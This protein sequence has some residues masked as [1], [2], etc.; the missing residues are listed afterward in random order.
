[1]T[2][3]LALLLVATLVAGG[4]SKP[5][6]SGQWVVNAA[7]S[8]FG[9]I[10]PPQCRGLKL[11]HREPELVSE[12]TRPGGEPC[13]LTLRYTTDGTP[14]TYT[15]NDARQRARMTWSGGTLVIERSSDD[16]VLMLIDATLSA[17]GRKL[18]VLSGRTAGC[19]ELDVRL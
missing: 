11:T 13:G 3:L 10:P 5:D 16:G 18:T 6:C 19:D 9:L 7:E 4:A 17:D 12:E 15:A 14:I 1:M 2:P 8:D